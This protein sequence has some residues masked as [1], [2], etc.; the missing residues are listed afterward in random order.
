M[1]H[2]IKRLAAVQA[3]IRSLLAEEAELKFDLDY[4]ALFA[5]A[6][7]TECVHVLQVLQFKRWATPQLYVDTKGLQSIQGWQLA[8]EIHSSAADSIVISRDMDT[9]HVGMYKTSPQGRATVY[10]QKYDS[11]DNLLRDYVFITYHNFIP[12]YLQLTTAVDTIELGDLTMDIYDVSE[13]IELARR[14][15][16]LVDVIRHQLPGKTFIVRDDAVTIKPGFPGLFE[17]AKKHANIRVLT[18]VNNRVY[19]TNSIGITLLPD[20][21]EFIHSELSKLWALLSQE[22]STWGRTSA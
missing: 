14:I 5:A 17:L 20:G 15:L 10:T 22:I 11:I 21:A 18:D 1:S 13:D 2:R 3:L 4:A 16:C 8:Q 9:Y 19:F 12:Q 7:D 6:P